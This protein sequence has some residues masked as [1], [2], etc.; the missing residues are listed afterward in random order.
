MHI[1]VVF[2]Y[3]EYTVGQYLHTMLYLLYTNEML[4]LSTF[5]ILNTSFS[6]NP[7]SFWWLSF[8]KAHYFLYI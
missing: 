4:R 1:P 6:N 7:L 3:I 2:S 8:V 5:L